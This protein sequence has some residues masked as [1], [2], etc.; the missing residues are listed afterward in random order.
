MREIFL[1]NI[2]GQDRPGLTAKL[3][4]ILGSFGAEILDIGQAVIHDHL[5]L[6]LVVAIPGERK[7]SPVLKEVLY[8]AHGLGVSVNFE[9][10]DEESYGAWV[11]DQ[12]RQR[13]VITLLNRRLTAQ[14]IASV[15]DELAS[16]G[17]NIDQITR[18]SS[19][20]ALETPESS[21]RACVEL[22]VSGPVED[23][24]ALR[25]RLFEIS[26]ESGVDVS[27]QVDDIYRR[28]RRLVAFDMDSTLIQ[29]EVIDELAKAAGSGEEVS[30]ITAAAMRGELDF[31]ES[32]RRRVA[33]LEGLDES[34]LEQIAERLPLSE[35]VER[36][37]TTLKRLGYKLAIL[38]GGFDYFGK[39]LQQRLGF[40]YV[41]ANQLEIV[42]RKLT[43]RVLG[44]VVDGARK[45]ELLEEIARA[46][47]I[48]LHQTIAVGDG[49]NDLPMLGVAGLGV[50]F[51]P[52]PIVAQKAARAIS[53]VGLDALLY[54]IGVR[55]R[56]TL[57]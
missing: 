21:G 29:A 54:L 33:T 45:A 42:D 44:R 34:V 28:S 40:D 49:A 53:S 41:H 32:L 7:S 5:S 19:R 27:F 16:Q 38:S 13:H 17:L 51:H 50:A 46:E 43:G 4:A 39:R 18:L 52:K 22:L 1:L 8:A 6:G 26:Q 11:G 12:G 15:A 2:A 48:A 3:T 37:V 36:L 35:G 56:D 24:L 14:Q 20:L 25:R 9:P 47:G 10:I 23:E 31:T 57:S 30:K 55:D